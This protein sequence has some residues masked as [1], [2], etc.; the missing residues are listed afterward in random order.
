L[1]EKWDLYP[2]FTAALLFFEAPADFFATGARR[3]A[4]AAAPVR[5]SPETRAAPFP[6]SA[7]TS[8][9]CEIRR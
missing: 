2:Y 1:R 3:L 9:I 4:G 7:N 6:R 8:V 5:P